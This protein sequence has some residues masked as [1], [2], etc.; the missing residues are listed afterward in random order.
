MRHYLEFFLL[1][2]GLSLG[3]L[4]LASLWIPKILK[5]KEKLVALTPLMRELW[6]TY[7]IYVYGS[8]IFFTVLALGFRD[9]LLGRTAGAAA[10][11]SFIFLWWTV[12]LYLQFFGLIWPEKSGHG[13]LLT[14]GSHHEEKTLHCRV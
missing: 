2:G 9:F 4:C 6:W 12:R 13:I 14:R 1:L 5:W 3:A 11:S 7:S 8:H 10:M